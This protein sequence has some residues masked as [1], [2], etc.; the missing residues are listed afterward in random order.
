[1]SYPYIQLKGL[2]KS[3]KILLVVTV[4]GD[5]VFFFLYDAVLLKLG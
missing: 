5:K 3:L 4:L 1:M 2:T